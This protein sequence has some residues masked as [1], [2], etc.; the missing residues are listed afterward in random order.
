MM[1]EGSSR[2]SELLGGGLHD[3]GVD[4]GGMRVC[5][6]RASGFF[7]RGRSIRCGSVAPIAARRL[8]RGEPSEG[9]HASFAPTDSRNAQQR[10]QLRFQSRF[11][12]SHA[13]RHPPVIQAADDHR[14]TWKVDQSLLAAPASPFS[15]IPKSP[16]SE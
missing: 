2:I 12:D 9:G 5:M 4:D 3:A 14:L 7:R 16:W 6:K 8:D 13:T 15:Q 11:A 1:V 10:A